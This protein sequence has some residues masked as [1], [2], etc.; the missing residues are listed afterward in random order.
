MDVGVIGLGHMGAAIAERLLEAGHDV[1]VYNRTESKADPLIAQ[2]AT[3]AHD[4]AGAAQ[5]SGRTGTRSSRPRSA[6]DKGGPRR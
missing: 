3:L 6:H 5:G 4:P 2:G 1:T